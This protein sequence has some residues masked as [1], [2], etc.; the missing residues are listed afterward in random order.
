MAGMLFVTHFARAGQG[1]TASHGGSWRFV[2]Q[3]SSV[4]SPTLA[5]TA[6]CR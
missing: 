4:R 5:R 3:A 2:R 1:T 6:H